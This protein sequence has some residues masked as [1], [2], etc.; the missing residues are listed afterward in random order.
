LYFGVYLAVLALVPHLALALALL[1]QSVPHIGKEFF[2]VA[3]GTE[4][5]RVITR[6]FVTVVAVMRL[7]ASLTSIILPPVPRIMLSSFTLVKT[8]AASWM[9]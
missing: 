9:Q 8:L 7:K 1:N 3:T 4:K 6:D 2:I 5:I